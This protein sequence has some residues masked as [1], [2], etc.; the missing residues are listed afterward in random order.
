MP[1]A[2]IASF[3]LMEGGVCSGG[4]GRGGGVAVTSAV[5]RCPRP[6]PNRTCY[7]MQKVDAAGDVMVRGEA[8][9]ALEREEDVWRYSWTESG[10]IAMHVTVCVEEHGEARRGTVGGATLTV[11]FMSLPSSV[12]PS[13]VHLWLVSGPPSSVPSP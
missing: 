4:E 7:I 8:R 10:K 3:P 13:R 5:R 6:R 2:Y 9:R 1:C 12:Q 11:W